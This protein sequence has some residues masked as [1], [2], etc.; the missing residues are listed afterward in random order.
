MTSIDGTRRVAVVRRAA[1]ICFALVAVGCGSDD[2]GD[3]ATSTT[4]E[5]GSTEN[6]SDA[7]ENC[8]SRMPGEALSAAEAVV[9]FSQEA[10]CPAY[11]T[12]VVGTP[13]TWHNLDDVE[14]TVRIVDGQTEDGELVEEIPLQPDEQAERTFEEPGFLTFTTDALPDARGTVELQAEAG[15]SPLDAD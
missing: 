1:V 5:P 8:S 6:A 14:R 2:G 4:A 3:D 13:V 9:L 15:Q 10:V 12:V 11:V 7:L